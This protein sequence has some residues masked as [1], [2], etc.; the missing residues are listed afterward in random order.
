MLYKGITGNP[1]G[2]YQIVL[3]FGSKEKVNHYA[4]RL[5]DKIRNK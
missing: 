2:A 4:I 3:V 1:I 5:Y